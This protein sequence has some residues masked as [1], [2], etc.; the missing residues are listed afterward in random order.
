MIIKN[1]QIRF[2]GT[3]LDIPLH[4]EE[5]RAR[6]GLL[7]LISVRL[8]E[9][10]TE[11]M[12]LLNSLAEKDEKGNPK[13]KEDGKEYDLT[14]ENWVEFQNKMAIRNDE[15]LEF[16][17]SKK[18]LPVVKKLIISIGNQHLF[19]IQDGRIYDE[20]CKIFGV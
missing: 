9:I 3:W 15:E 19:K 14:T 6:A 8:N 5:A 4:G 1:Y 18:D 12:E 11:R 2:L 7:R 17:I 20:L 10:E 13:L 16:D